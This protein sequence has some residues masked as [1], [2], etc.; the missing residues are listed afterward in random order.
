LDAIF[1]IAE[2]VS[3][4]ACELLFALV[5]QNAKFQQLSN[6]YKLAS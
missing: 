1:A 3:A 4:D 2:L 6:I 5:S